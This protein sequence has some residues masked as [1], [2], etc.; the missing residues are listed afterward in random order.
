M[1]SSAREI[2]P[3]RAAH[4][5]VEL[6]GVA[7]LLHLVI[8]G[9]L[10]HEVLSDLRHQL[11]TAGIARGQ[12]VELLVELLPLLA[13]RGQGLGLLP[14]LWQAWC[15][16]GH[17]D[18]Q[19]AEGD[20]ISAG[21]QGCGDER[22]AAQFRGK[23]S[24]KTRTLE[25]PGGFLFLPYLGL[26]HEGQ[27]DGDGNGWQDARH[28]QVAP[29]GGVVGTEAG[30]QADVWQVHSVLADPHA[31]QRHQHAAEGGEGLGDAQPLFPLLPVLKHFRQPGD[32]GHELHTHTDEG[33]AAEEDKHLQRGGIGGGKG[34]EGIEEDAGPHDGFAA[35]L[36]HQPAAQQA[37]DTAAEGGDPQQVPHPARDD[38]I[39]QGQ[40][41]QLGD[42][43]RGH[44][45]GHQ[46]LIGV[47]E[48]TDAGD[49]NDQPVGGGELGSGRGHEWDDAVRNC[50]ASQRVAEGDSITRVGTG[51]M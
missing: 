34:G 7:H 41:Q 27:Q 26:R 42:G 9:F 18:L 17:S 23:E 28:Q 12:G 13:Q 40:L 51:G 5:L 20:A 32:G 43:W 11:P 38:G 37:E 31:D 15:H 33:R 6:H 35:K 3:T 14:H 10:L 30:R 21:G 47:E 39:V 29:G 24:A 16:T 44:Q 49:D 25:Q 48:E 4:L 2:R 1:S 22:H 46:E 36:V 8:D 50:E 19:G 45:G